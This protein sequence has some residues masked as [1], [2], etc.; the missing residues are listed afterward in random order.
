MALPSRMTVADYPALDRAS[1]DQRY[2]FT[3]GQIVL[4]AGGTANHATIRM[5][6]VALLRDAARQ[7]GCRVYS[8][9]LRVRLSETRYVYP[10][11][12]VTCD[13]R[14]RGQADAVTSPLLVVEVLSPGTEAY[15]RGKKLAYYRQCPTIQEYVLIDAQRPS[16]EIYRRES[17]SF[18]AYRAF[19]G[20]EEA[21]CASIGARFP[22]AAVY[23]DVTLAEDDESANR[24]D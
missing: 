18:W 13:E 9:D 8:S 4:L 17:E 23:A 1:P 24:E 5:N 15:D 19:T 10:D 22:L 20:E 2:E 11:C 16:A 21:E 3:D 7:R 14:D 6:M 12:T